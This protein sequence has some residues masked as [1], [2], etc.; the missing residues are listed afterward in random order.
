MIGS[1]ASLFILGLNYNYSVGQPTVYNLVITSFKIVHMCME[2]LAPWQGDEAYTAMTPTKK[3]SRQV[4]PTTV[5]IIEV[6]HRSPDLVMKMQPTRCPRCCEVHGYIDIHMN[7][8]RLAT[9]ATPY[10]STKEF[11]KNN[12]FIFIGNKVG[13]CRP[14]G[15]PK[16]GLCYS[17][18]NRQKGLHNYNDE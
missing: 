14:N 4:Q 9:S 7:G 16:L 11:I 5:S 6:I 17:R 2:T 10:H 3:Q 8:E 1:I 13:Y 18:S 15:R 12:L